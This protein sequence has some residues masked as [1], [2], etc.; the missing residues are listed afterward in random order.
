MKLA[1]KKF[2]FS[3]DPE[4]IIFEIKLIIG[5][6]EVTIPYIITFSKNS[7]AALLTS[8]PPSQIFWITIDKSFG[9]ITLNQIGA[10]MNGGM[11]TIYLDAGF[12]ISIIRVTFYELHASISLKLDEL[13]RLGLNGLAISLEKPPL[14]ISGGVFR[15]K[16]A[17]GDFYTGELVLGFTKFSF[18]ILASYGILQ[19]GTHSMFA[20]LVLNAK[21]GGPPFLFVTGLSIGFGLNREIILPAK[22]TDVQNFPFVA[23]A[24]GDLKWAGI[25]RPDEMLKEMGRII[26]PKKDAYF[27]SA[28]LRFTSFGFLDTFVVVNAAFGNDFVLSVLGLSRL[29]VPPRVTSNQIARAELA[30]K[31]VY[32]SDSDV[33]FILASLMNDSFVFHRNC[34]LT[35]SFAFYSWLKGPHQNDFVVSLGGYNPR[36]KKRGHYPEVDRIRIN[37]RV[38]NH[39]TLSGHAYFALTP[40]MLMAGG[41]LSLVYSAGNLKAWLIAN[42][43]FTLKWK[44][45]FY[46]ADMMVRVGASYRLQFLFIDRTFSIELSAQIFMQGPEFCGWARIRWF[47]ISFTI[48]FNN[49]PK[50]KPSPLVWTEFRDDFLVP[51]QDAPAENHCL[52]FSNENS[53]ICA[54]EP[55]GIIKVVRNEQLDPVSYIMKYR[56]LSFNVLSRLPSANIIFAYSDG[57]R[58]VERVVHSGSGYSIRPMNRA[59]F[60]STMTI[61]LYKISNG[62]ELIN[63]DCK[64]ILQKAPPALWGRL[65]PVNPLDEDMLDDVPMGARVSPI[66]S[67]PEGK[68]PIK[69]PAYPLDALTANEPIEHSLNWLNPV[70]PKGK[71]YT[72]DPDAVYRK[73]METI[74]SSAVSNNRKELIETKLGSFGLS[75]DTD[76]SGWS[77]INQLFAAPFLRT[78]GAAATEA[79]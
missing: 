22:V 68:I 40:Y 26:V 55:D 1:L 38:T 43:D 69:S 15:D 34:K 58:E 48:T 64:P 39:I 8:A 62:N 16:T 2:G 29:S 21:I 5:S 45:F 72:D 18:T 23:A 61:R 73:I 20:Y 57:T 36:F 54:I 17:L 53:K 76:L 77:N 74:N 24:M 44:P 33:F 50:P 31:S 42:A 11:I 32:S 27:V 9:F 63:A 47:I 59:A 6:L 56:S 4:R 52:T 78:T 13:P 12:Y 7:N 3:V 14:K 25:K 51:P 28:G 19:D 70:Q 30:I 37:W 67:R 60:S 46:E 71:T 66:F 65:N 10:A 41:G 79:E 35:G 49:Y 75:G